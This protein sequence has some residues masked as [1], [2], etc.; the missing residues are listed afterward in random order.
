GPARDRVAPLLSREEAGV[1]GDRAPRFVLERAHARGV[2]REAVAA[3]D[4]CRRAPHLLADR[5]A[6][7]GGIDDARA[8]ADTAA[9]ERQRERD[10]RED[11]R[12]RAVLP[13]QRHQGSA[14]FADEEPDP[15][16]RP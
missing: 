8:E 12:R 3:G 11:E 5:S 9:P 15:V 13:E 10:E 16:A 2:Q 7:D 14:A 4:E 1:A 6:R